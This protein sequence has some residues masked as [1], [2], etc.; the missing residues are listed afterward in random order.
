MS[1]PPTTT[2][3]AF[4]NAGRPQSMLTH[5]TRRAKSTKAVQDRLVNPVWQPFGHNRSLSQVRKEICSDQN[6]GLE[7]RSSQTNIEDL[8]TSN[9]SPK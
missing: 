8:G 6:G 5:R 3:R 7:A 9:K 2:Q 4:Y 1:R